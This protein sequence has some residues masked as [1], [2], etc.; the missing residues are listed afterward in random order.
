MLQNWIEIEKIY[1]NSMKKVR[2]KNF[3]HYNFT[4]LYLGHY[5]SPYTYTYKALRNLRITKFHFIYDA[6]NDSIFGQR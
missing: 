5:R 6:F 4:E 1:L 3:L 2:Y